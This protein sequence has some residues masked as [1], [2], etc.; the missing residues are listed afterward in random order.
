MLSLLRAPADTQ[1]S[2]YTGYER[3]NFFFSLVVVVFFVHPARL[4]IPVLLALAHS[5]I[6]SL[7][8]YECHY[9]HKKIL[10]AEAWQSG[11]QKT[12][13]RSRAYA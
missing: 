11:T 1:P 4:A 12:K 5:M 13:S 8:A 2:R 6:Y 7:R 9:D 3:M 10:L